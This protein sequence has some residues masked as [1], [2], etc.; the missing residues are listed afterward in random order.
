MISCLYQEYK[1]LGAVTEK[2][3]SA[4]R[5]MGFRSLRLISCEL[6]VK[7]SVRKPTDQDSFILVLFNCHSLKIYTA[8]FGNTYVF[9]FALKLYDLNGDF[10]DTLMATLMMSHVFKKILYVFSKIEYTFSWS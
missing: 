6:Y 7:L 9:R 1:L 2:L 10:D 4:Q 3:M 8:I 5:K